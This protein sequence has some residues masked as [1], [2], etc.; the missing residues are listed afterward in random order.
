MLCICINVSIN[1]WARDTCASERKKYVV[2]PSFMI[3]QFDRIKTKD[4]KKDKI[5]VAIKDLNCRID[6]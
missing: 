1:V 3:G 6:Y 4:T 2:E 5:K